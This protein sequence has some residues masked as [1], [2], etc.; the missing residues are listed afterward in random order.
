M[1]VSIN[2]ADITTK[3]GCEL[4]IT[5]AMKMGPVGGI[6]ILSAVLEEG[7]L[8]NLDEA[9]FLTVL[10]PKAHATAYLDEVSRK[11]CPELKH[12]VVFSSVACGRGNY[13]QTNYGMSNSLAERIMERRHADGLPA[14]AIQW[15]PG[16]FDNNS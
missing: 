12:F 16:V 1:E 6:F 5:D 8:V 4:L 13:G 14:K 7:M 11:L 10:K 9:K 3:A 2:N 15:G